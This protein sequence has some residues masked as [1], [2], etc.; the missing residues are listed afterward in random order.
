MIMCVEQDE[1]AQPHIPMAHIHLDTL[2]DRYESVVQRIVD[3][4]ET[5]LPCRGKEL[6]NEERCK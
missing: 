2:H 1:L 5:L 6:S 4:K 3:L